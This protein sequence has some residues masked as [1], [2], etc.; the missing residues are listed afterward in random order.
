MAKYKRLFSAIPV[1]LIRIYQIA[2]SPYFGYGQ[3]RF[4]PCCSEYG[5]EAFKQHGL[6]VGFWFILKRLLKC[7]PLHKGGYDPVPQSKL[8]KNKK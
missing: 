4:Y 2:I 3:C 1:A 7:H 5:K 8:I 6:I